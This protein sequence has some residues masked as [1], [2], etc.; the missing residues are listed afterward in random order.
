MPAEESPSD[1]AY[2]DALERLFART[3]GAWKLG[4]ER[5]SVFFERVGNPHLAYPVFHVAGTNGKGSTVATLTALL[6]GAGLRVGRYTSP[7]L[8]DFAN[9]S[10]WTAMQFRRLP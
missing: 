7:Q 4:L 1:V 6:R 9:A 3:T 5:V 10:W 2:H 8:V